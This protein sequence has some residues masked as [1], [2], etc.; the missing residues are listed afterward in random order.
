MSAE[1]IERIDV[2][3][4]PSFASFNPNEVMD[5]TSERYGLNYAYFLSH[6]PSEAP[7]C[8]TCFL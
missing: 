6:S 5:I 2:A 7:I 4:V 3:Y 1:E 8:L